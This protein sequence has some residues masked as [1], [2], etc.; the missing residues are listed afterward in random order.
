M[1]CA[2]SLKAFVTKAAPAFKGM[3]YCPKSK[4]F[5][6]VSLEDYKDKYLLLFFY[7]LDF[8][9]VCPTEIIQFSNLA[10]KFNDV[11]C[12]VLGCSIDSHF[13]H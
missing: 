9:F 3:S 2:N 4:S 11:N 12:E 8:T 5:K 13:S 6:P 1:S 10:K 7:P